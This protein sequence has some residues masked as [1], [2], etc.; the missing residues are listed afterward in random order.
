MLRRVGAAAL[1]HALC[2]PEND[3]QDSEVARLDVRHQARAG[4]P[5]GRMDRADREKAGKTLW[6][7]VDGGYVKA[8]FCAAPSHRGDGHR[9]AA[10]GRVV[11]DLPP[12]S[13]GGK[14]RGR[15][16]PPNT[17]RTASAC[18]AGRPSRRLGNGRMHRLW[19]NDHQTLQDLPGD[20]PAGGRS[21]SCG[22]RAGRTRLVSV[23]LDRPE[24]HGRG[25]HRSL[26][27][28]CD[29]RTGLPRRQGSVGTGQQQVRNIWTNVAVY[30]LN[31]WMHTLVELWAWNRSH[32]Q[33]CDRR[34]S[35]WDDAD[36]RP[37]H[38]DRRN[39]LRR[40][41]L[42]AEFLAAAARRRLPRKI[43]DFFKQLL[44][45]AC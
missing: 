6:I 8:P 24:R 14:R 13:R 23:L 39:S 32:H 3:G 31:L 9:T 34:L 27:R 11:R 35:P 5:A 10:Q 17:A 36:R 45:L 26:R 38:A 22:D 43:R 15:G 33:L 16:R 1:G 4:C 40:N 19:K 28:P 29:D 44:G 2:P 25:D 7:V 41:I 21:D 30:H 42:R 12:K 18:Q 37:S 20:L